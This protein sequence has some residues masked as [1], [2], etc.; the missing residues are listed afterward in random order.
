VLVGEVGVGK[1]ALG[2]AFVL[3]LQAAQDDE[4]RDDPEDAGVAVIDHLPERGI[5]FF[6]GLYYTAKGHNLAL[7]LGLE[8]IALAFF[9]VALVLLQG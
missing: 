1:E 7:L 3:V 8:K 6:G 4:T 2:Q 9:P 5:F